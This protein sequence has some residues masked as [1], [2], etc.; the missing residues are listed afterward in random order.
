MCAS[1][2]IAA[3]DDAA[4]GGLRIDDRASVKHATGGFEA[5]RER[6]G[7]V[8]NFERQAARGLG[9]RAVRSGIVLGFRTVRTP[10]G[11]FESA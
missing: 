1:S 6:I 5:V 10:F 2:L 8:G 7:K 9:S 11:K 4:S 3:A